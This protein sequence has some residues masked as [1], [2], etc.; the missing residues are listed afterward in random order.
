LFWL[1]LGM[2]ALLVTVMAAVGAWWWKHR[3]M[4]SMEQENAIAVLPLQNVKGDV[5]V[6]YLRFAL[7]DELTSVLTYSRSLEVRPTSAT[8]KF[9]DQDGDFRKVGLQLRVGRL[10][11]GHFLEQGDQLSVTL[12]AVDVGSDRLLWQTTVT[13]P[14]NDLISLQNQLTTQVQQ[15]LLPALG[16]GGTLSTASRPKSPEA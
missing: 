2:A 10:L 7:A 9:A 8:R 1:V 6:D 11:T 15:G 3:S 16:A 14:V 4:A 5:A 13:V 12:E